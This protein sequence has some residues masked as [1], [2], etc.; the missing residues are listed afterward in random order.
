M[1]WVDDCCTHT[2]K[3][4]VILMLVMLLLL[5]LVMVLLLLLLLDHKVIMKARL[6]SG[7]ALRQST[8]LG[9]LSNVGINNLLIRVVLAKLLVESDQAW[10]IHQGILRSVDDTTSVTLLKLRLAC[11]VVADWCIEVTILPLIS[12]A[13]DHGW[14]VVMG[15]HALCTI[16]RA[17]IAPSSPVRVCQL[18]LVACWLFDPSFLRTTRLWTWH[19]PWLV[20]HDDWLIT[21]VGT[22]HKL[23]VTASLRL[24]I[25]QCNT[26]M[27]LHH[28]LRLR[29][30]FDV[31]TLQHHSLQTLRLLYIIGV[32]LSR[33]LWING[34]PLY[35]ICG[36]HQLGFRA[37]MPLIKLDCNVRMW[38][39]FIKLFLRQLVRVACQLAG[40]FQ[41]SSLWVQ[42]LLL[43]IGLG[44]FRLRHYIRLL[45]YS[46]FSLLRFG[47][48]AFSTRLGL[49]DA[50]VSG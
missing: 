13:R 12:R 26:V 35:L 17:L 11:I 36:L 44:H 2:I 7:T 47:L 4:R 46:I 16:L 45:N 28:C 38:L 23:T 15:G 14:G 30:K 18:L 6:E 39:V 3:A 34:R 37:T 43:Q 50:H 22:L 20:V 40:S 10:V 42:S 49:F 9:H 48:S 27:H 29:W 5:L 25:Q 21:D 8:S 41:S 32:N 31:L 33:L 1:C 24:L 19:C